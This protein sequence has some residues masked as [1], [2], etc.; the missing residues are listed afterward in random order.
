VGQVSC[1]FGWDA[2]PTRCFPPVLLMTSAQKFPFSRIPEPMPA[3]AYLLVAHGSRDPRPQYALDALAQ[4]VREAIAHR[5]PA[6][7]SSTG[8]PPPDA[9]ATPVET[10]CLELQPQPLHQQILAFVDRA[11]APSPHPL[12]HPPA[13]S[14]VPL[15]LL[16]GVHVMDD[17]PAEVAIAQRALGDRVHLQIY[18][19]LGETV[20]LA[21]ALIPL[22]PPRGSLIL[23]SHGSRRPGGN[24][25]IEHLAQRLKATVAY[26]SISPGLEEQLLRQVQQ[27]CQ[28]ITVLPYILF[29]AGITDAIATT[30]D[31]LAY[32]YPQVR[33]QALPALSD[34]APLAEWVLQS[35][36]KS[37]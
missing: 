29:P 32:R 20:D 13:L 9:V 15:F 12:P 21:Q 16:P 18:P 10:A 6:A 4:Q 11:I 14:I 2:H 30:L 24:V 1:S 27:G 22:M 8:S 25:P 36:S 37:P 34:L 26:W 5:T 35:L 33:F 28:E 3:S 17:I 7:V 23:M 19:Y 31:T